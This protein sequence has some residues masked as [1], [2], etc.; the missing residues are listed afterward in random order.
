MTAGVCPPLRS[1]ATWP[2]QLSS[3]LDDRAAISSAIDESTIEANRIASILTTAAQ[4]GERLRSEQHDA[5]ITLVNRVELR[6]DSMRVALRLPL[7]SPAEG[8][9]DDGSSHLSIAR[10]VPMRLRRRGVELRLIID[11]D[12]GPSRKTDQALLS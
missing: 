3:I 9:S 5:L 8:V 10:W 7:S 11:G 2:S 1:S 12:R 6:P 4:W